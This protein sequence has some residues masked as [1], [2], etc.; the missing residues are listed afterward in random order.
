MAGITYQEIQPPNDF[1]F[2]ASQENEAQKSGSRTI[3][4]N[5]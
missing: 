1:A 2:L 3:T 5:L 4:P